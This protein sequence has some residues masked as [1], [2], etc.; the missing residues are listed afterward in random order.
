MAQTTSVNDAGSGIVGG[1]RRAFA[2]LTLPDQEIGAANST[3]QIR[4]AVLKRDIP[5][6]SK[7]RFPKRKIVFIDNSVFVEVGGDGRVG[8][9]AVHETAD[10]RRIEISVGVFAHRR[11]LR[12]EAGR[13][14]QDRG[15]ILDRTVRVGRIKTPKLACGKVGEDISTLHLGIRAPVN[16]S[17]GNGI[18]LEV[19]VASRFAEMDVV[20]NRVN[21]SRWTIPADDVSRLRSFTKP[22]TII[23]AA[24]AIR[25]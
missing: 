16:E 21:A 10:V 8:D 13:R 25:S 6:P 12:G 5:G 11:H 17:A 15:D 23:C 3:I 18:A 7:A 20:V 24:G 19:D 1:R 2:V 14:R 22:P 4:I 9:D